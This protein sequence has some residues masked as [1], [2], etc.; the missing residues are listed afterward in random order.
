MRPTN[1]SETRE[2]C[3]IEIGEWQQRSRIERRTDRDCRQKMSATYFI[4]GGLERR[5]GKERRRST[6]R[7]DGWLR[8]G[9]WRSEIVFDD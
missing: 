5:S 8:V 3:E 6:E 4:S 9:K 1:S 2:N 7:R